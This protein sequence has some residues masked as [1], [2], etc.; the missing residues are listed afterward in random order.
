V[1]FDVRVAFVVL[2]ADVVF[3]AM[4]LDEVHLE[5]ERLEFRP[6]DDP[7]D[8]RDLAHQA[9]RLVVV[10]GIRVEIRAD[11]VLQA[12]RLADVDDFPLGIFHQVAAGLCGQ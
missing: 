7:F 8:V 6:D 2:Q 11:A 5:D 12:D 10:T 3:R 9:A 1:D 4:F